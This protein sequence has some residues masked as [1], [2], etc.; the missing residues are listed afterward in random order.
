MTCFIPWRAPSGLNGFLPEQA[1]HLPDE[2]TP[3]QLRREQDNL[4]LEMHDTGVG[5]EP[6]DLARIFDR[7]YRSRT[8]ANEAR[9]TGL[10]LVIAKRIVE[11]HRG[12]VSIVSRSR[13]DLHGDCPPPT[14]NAL[15]DICGPTDYFPR[16]D[17]SFSAMAAWDGTPPL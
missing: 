15:G 7:F 11:V 10:G 13:R 6:Q 5:I 17:F 4:V 3:A 12:N 9:G 8:T 2:V 14:P 1:S 16:A